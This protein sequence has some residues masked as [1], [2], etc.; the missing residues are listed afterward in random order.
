MPK[1]LSGVEDDAFFDFDAMYGV[2]SVPGASDALRVFAARLPPS[3]RDQ[4]PIAESGHGR[5]LRQAVTGRERARAGFSMYA[6][7]AT[8][9]GGTPPGDD[10][11]RLAVGSV[12]QVAN[13]STSYVPITD[14]SALHGTLIVKDNLGHVSAVGWIVA[15]WT[16]SWSSDGPCVYTFDGPCQAV[17]RFLP[18]TAA[19]AGAGATALVVDD[20]ARVGLGNI[21]SI[22][23]SGPSRAIIGESG[24]TKTLD[25]ADTWSDGD[26]VEDG[27]PTPSY[28]SIADPLFA[29][30]GTLSFD[31]GTTDVKFVSGQLSV[32]TGVTLVNSESGT[33]RATGVVSAARRRVSFRTTFAAQED[34]LDL[35]AEAR[36]GPIKDTHL[37]L[38]PATGRR[39]LLDM[40]QMQLGSP[41][42]SPNPEGVTTAEISGVATTTTKDNELTLSYL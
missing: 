29:T 30:V 9:A 16:L 1:F 14:Q 13:T 35:V 27:L 42:E 7:P 17:R 21:V 28:P 24:T 23:T 40:P 36:S 10:I 37:T 18:T 32:Q 33:V 15:N 6:R 3:I 39:L 2:P 31:G 34:V 38:G 8:A 26:A 4:T 22:G 20:A 5:S 41:T 19:A 25:S 11:L 12:V